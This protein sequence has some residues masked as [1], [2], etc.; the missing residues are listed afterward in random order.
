MNGIEMCLEIKSFFLDELVFI[1]KVLLQWGKGM[2]RTHKTNQA[3][4]GE[5]RDRSKK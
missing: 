1:D 3:I 2:Q 5:E 4:K